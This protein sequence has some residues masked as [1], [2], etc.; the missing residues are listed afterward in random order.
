MSWTRKAAEKAA[1][2]IRQE[3]DT[4]EAEASIA[5]TTEN[6]RQLMN[7]VDGMNH[8][9]LILRKEFGYEF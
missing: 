1:Q 3:I 9:L 6:R 5:E 8:A 7:K 4:L 2:K